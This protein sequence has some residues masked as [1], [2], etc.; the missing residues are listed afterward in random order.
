MKR[1]HF[2]IIETPEHQILIE[3]YFKLE[4]GDPPYKV[5]AST[6]TNLSSRTCVHLS[7]DA[8]SKQQHY[9]ENNTKELADI[10]LDAIAERKE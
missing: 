9:F 8:P 7:F 6:Y 1:I 5:V 2:Q 10:L 3:R 4:Q